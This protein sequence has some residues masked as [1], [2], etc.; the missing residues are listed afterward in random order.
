MMAAER[1]VRVSVLVRRVAFR[2]SR[3]GDAMFG[4]RA[5]LEDGFGANR[6]KRQGRSRTMRNRVFWSLGCAALKRLDSLP[7]PQARGIA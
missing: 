4:S 6:D 7:V 3:V 5:F 1:R 2:I